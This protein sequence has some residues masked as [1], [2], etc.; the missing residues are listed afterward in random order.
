MSS[1]SDNEKSQVNPEDLLSSLNLG[2]AWARDEGKKPRSKSYT[3][4]SSEEAR[5]DRGS[6]PPRGKGRDFKGKGQRGPRNRQDR[7]HRGNNDR[8]NFS[9]PEIPA[10]E[11]VTGEVMP[12]EE[13][14]D[15]AAKDI[16]ATARTQEVFYLAKLILSSRD[17]YRVN[18]KSADD[19][20]KMYFCR[21]DGSVWLKKEEALAHFKRAAWKTDFYETVLSECEPPKGNYSSVAKC[22]MSGEL[23]GPPNY[24]GYQE[25]LHALHAERFS[26]M[27]IERYRSKIVV[28]KGEEVVE[29]WLKA[30]SQKTSYRPYGEDRDFSRKKEE[31]KEELEEKVTPSETVENPKEENK[32]PLVEETKAVETSEV[33]APVENDEDLLTTLNEVERHFLKNHFESIFSE[34]DHVYVSGDITGKLLSPPLFTL[35]KSVV[36]E[37]LRYPGKLSAFMCRQLS[38]RHLAIFKWK[39]KLKAGPA[40]PHAVPEDIVIANRPREILDW[41]RKNT[42]NGIDKLWKA[43]LSENTSEEDKKAW[44][45]DLH[46]LINQGYVLFMHDGI[47]HLAKTQVKQTKPEAK[48]KKEPKVSKES[49]V[50]EVKS[51]GV[52]APKGEEEK[53]A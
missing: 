27:A 10:P 52:E 40:R 15:I 50:S 23:L 48:V 29:A 1:S 5:S 34:Q 47:L 3:K 22:S 38:G 43:L 18:F 44:Y 19:T 35:L 14:L 20:K 45:G 4:G 49:K 25:R 42:G 21:K 11:Y 8:P 12:Y 13:A 28:E 7:N 36:S 16:I 2:P 17:R 46:W 33:E 41:V 9:K 53:E 26:N 31:V 24:H 32:E 39:G 37:E 30:M 51:G 6:R